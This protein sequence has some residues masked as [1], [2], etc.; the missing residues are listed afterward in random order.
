[1]TRRLR[2]LQSGTVGGFLNFYGRE[3]RCLE[4]LN[5]SIRIYESDIFLLSFQNFVKTDPY[6]SILETKVTSKKN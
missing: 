1:M 5:L 3:Q 4:A 6:F 2:L